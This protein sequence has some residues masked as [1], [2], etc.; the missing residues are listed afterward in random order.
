MI[1]W[2][3]K[4][5]KLKGIRIVVW[6]NSAIISHVVV[7]FN[8]GKGT[9]SCDVTNN[10][11]LGGENYLQIWRTEWTHSLQTV[12]VGTIKSASDPRCRRS[13]A[14]QHEWDSEGVETLPNEIVNRGGARPG[15]ISSEDTLECSL[16]TAI[17]FCNNKRTG[18]LPSP[19]SAPDWFTPK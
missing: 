9:L 19:N 14:L 18:I 12:E 8:N 17:H 2:V 11:P 7:G 5:L 10:L 3:E 16:T 4:S 15:V 1:R 13:K 6:D